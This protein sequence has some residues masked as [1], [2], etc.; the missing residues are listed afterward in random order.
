MDTVKKQDVLLLP[1]MA[2]LLCVCLISSR[3]LV[4]RI[5]ITPISNPPDGK[6]L[7]IENWVETNGTGGLLRRYLDLPFYI[8]D[9]IT[10][11]LKI[12]YYQSEYYSDNYQLTPF[13]CLIGKGESREGSAGSGIFDGL[14]YMS[15]LPFTTTISVST[16]HVKDNTPD[17]VSLPVEL[18][19]VSADGLIIVKIADEILLLD[20]GECWQRIKDAK[21]YNSKYNG[22]YH[23]KSTLCNYGWLDLSQLTP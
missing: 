10:K 21:V 14:D 7:F 9:P 16:G 22:V 2:F 1:I 4:G 13:L 3:S 6:F 5:T 8:F 15:T 19:S 23:I 18:R 17:M 12:N 11:V 20:V